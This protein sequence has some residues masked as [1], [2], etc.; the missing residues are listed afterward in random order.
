MPDEEMD[1]AVDFGQAGFGEDI[2]IDLDFPAGQPDEDMDLGDY[3]RVHDIHHFNSDTRD[4]LM[5]EGDDASYGMIDT[6]DP[7]HQASATIANDID[8]ELEHTVESIWQ[9]DPPPV[10]DLNP[11]TEIDYLDEATAESMD[12]DRND[13]EASE[14]LPAVMVSQNTDSMGHANEA[15]L[16][17]STPTQ[18]PHEELLLENCAPSGE[19][20]SEPI[21]ASHPDAEASYYS[22]PPGSNEN[23][24]SSHIDNP[25]DD[26]TAGAVT[27][28]S[29]QSSVVGQDEHDV[30]Q[31]NTGADTNPGSPTLKLQES[32]EPEPGNFDEVSQTGSD[33]ADEFSASHDPEQLGHPEAIGTSNL[34]VDRADSP[35][36]E[37]AG[38]AAGDALEYQV[39]DESYLDPTNDQA[40]ADAV[41]PQ[42]ESSARSRSDSKSAEDSP[43]RDTDDYPSEVVASIG[44]DTS[45]TGVRDRDD[46]I[47]LADYYG[48]YISYGE[49]DY[50]LFAKT[51]DDD[52]NQ[53]FLTD[54][55]ALD[56]SLTQF[57]TCLREVISE[58]ISP[59]DDLVMQ[60]D[61]LGIEFSESTTADFLG[62]FTFGDLVVLYDKLVKNEQ[63]ESSPP[64]YTYLTVRPNCNRRMMALG[65]SA[66]AGR[67]L[68]EVAL[69][70]DS[71][72]MYEDG[73][74]DVES[75]DTDFSTGDYND[76]ES[77]NVYPQDNYE[78]GDSFDDGEHQSSPPATT[79][80]QFES[81]LNQDKKSEEFDNDPEQNSG[82]GSA[83]AVDDVAV[84]ISKQG[85]YPLIF[86]CPF[87]CTQ[88][89]SCSC[90]DCYEIELQ[91]LATPTRAKVWPTPGGVV[92][93]HN[94]PMH[95]M[96]ITNR[97]M[98]KDHATSESLGSQTQEAHEDEPQPSPK[99]PEA[100]ESNPRAPKTTSTNPSTDA[101]N[102]ENTSVT[103]T[104]DGEDHDEIDYNSDEDDT[105]NHEIAD[106]PSSQNQPSGTPDLNQLADDEITWESDDEGTQNDAKNGLAKDTVQVSPVSGKRTRSD[107]AASDDAGDRNDYKRRRS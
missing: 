22:A 42:A 68:S 74:D 2:D 33:H 43:T 104:L 95:M 6:I 38:Q 89:G 19:E 54:K 77:S 60:I 13:V 73:A 9:Q 100:S 31:P 25:P 84:S 34:T 30:N 79:E 45:L 41:V 58:E 15:A 83:D 85:I 62:K 23:K 67:G 64:I 56:I 69:Y 44:A 65:E 4:E 29:N 26:G 52:P 7:D 1:M 17:P 20:S 28:S 12:A 66:N 81:V 3:D 102:S 90:E 36:L 40:S 99:I 8:I 59:L 11:D 71:I 88:K 106:E 14:W 72:S 16:Q 87:S 27:Q 80:A 86:H 93:T 94:S 103:A 76:G 21:K 51:E 35:Q 53:Y 48:V 55:S 97:T 63:A 98:T 47:E 5:A 96:W 91:H 10:A 92:P 39:G 107:S 75:P 24:Q 49:T 78:G 37:E 18:E 82:D 46:P 101:P 57:L 105:S 70:R 61:G 32:N 50:R